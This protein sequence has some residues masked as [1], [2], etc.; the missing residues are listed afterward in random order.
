L[1]TVDANVRDLIARLTLPDPWDLTA[2]VGQIARDRGRPIQLL[3]VEMR[4]SILHGLWVATARADYIAY[5]ARSTPFKRTAIV[6]HEIAHMVL[7]HPS[8]DLAELEGVPSASPYNAAHEIEADEF[9]EEILRRADAP[10]VA[11]PA[12]PDDVLRVI[13]TF[14]TDTS[15][16]D[17]HS[18]RSVR[19]ALRRRL[20]RIN[21]AWW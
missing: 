6:L 19:G 11:P 16:Y 21:P 4:G 12:E 1:S 10:P 9:A 3:S 8:R 2:L 14:G 13:D 5:P 18:S 17:L 7:R 20:H 15:T